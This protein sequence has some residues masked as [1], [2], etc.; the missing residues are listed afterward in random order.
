MHDFW[1]GFWKGRN[2]KNIDS[3]A[4]RRVVRVVSNYAKPGRSVLDAGCGSGYFSSYFISCG[5]DVYSLDYSEEALSVAKKI[6]GQKARMYI[7][8][9]VLAEE[10]ISAIKARFDMIFTDGLMEHYSGEEQDKIIRN[11]KTLKKQDGY[12]INFVPNRFSFWSMI[13]PFCM[14]IKERPFSMG[15]FL[16]LHIRNNLN[17]ISFGGLNVLPFRISP[18]RVLARHFGMLYYC[19]AV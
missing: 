13:R 7:K 5:C 11:M 3:W 6:T 4:K 19:V 9:D 17:I 15:E 8:G 14:R 1:D 16:N 10:N 12:I 2:M 18:E